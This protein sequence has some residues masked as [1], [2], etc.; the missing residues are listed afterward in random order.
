MA[1]PWM[2]AS[3][4]SPPEPPPHWV[5]RAFADQPALPLTV[6]VG[7][8]GYGKTLGLLALWQAARASADVPGL[9]VGCE[10]ED[11]D[12]ATFFP[13]LVAGLAER[14]P[15]FGEAVLALV[16][17]GKH[18]P[19]ALWQR[20]FEDVAGYNLPGFVL[21]LDDAHYLAAGSDGSL[22]RG[23]LLE[24]LAG[25]L[26]RLPPGCRLLLASRRKLPLALARWQA[27][28][29]ARVIGPEGLRFEAAE[30]RALYVG[31]RGGEPPAG[32]E[33]HV[34]ELEG[35][36]LGVDLA[37]AG[38]SELAAGADPALLAEVIAQELLG[39][40]EGDRQRFMLG[41]ALLAEPTATALAHALADERAAEHLAALEADQLVL[42]LARASHGQKPG[43][44]GPPADARYRFP[45]FLREYL[46]DEARRRLP[47]TER[48]AIHQR[49]GAFYVEQALDE[50]ALPHLQAAKAW[51]AA[52]AAGRRC[53]PIM[54]T[55]GRRA[56]V[57]RLLAGFPPE[58]GQQEPFLL[59]W[60][61]HAHV[62]AFELAAARAI[63]ERARE[64]SAARGD[65]AGEL[66][67]L[68][69]LANVAIWSGDEAEAARLDMAIQPILVDGEP[70]DR[71]DYP[72]ARALLAEAQGDP[73]G[74]RAHNE[75]VLDVP[76]GGSVEVAAART[77]ALINLASWAYHHGQLER[78][79][80]HGDE[81]VALAQEWRFYGHFRLATCIRALPDL[82]RGLPEGL[83]L[84]E[85]LPPRWEDALSFLELGVALVI[86]GWAQQARGEPKAADDALRR[87]MQLFE[88]S[89][90]QEGRKVALERLLSFALQ[91]G[92]PARVPA[93]LAEHLPEGATGSGQHDVPLQL[94][95]GRA[96][97]LL[98]QHAEARA[99]LE[100][101]IAG[102]DAL[103]APLEA[104]RARLFLAATLRATADPGAEAMLA[105]A[106]HAIAA[107]GYAFL[108]EQDARLWNELAAPATHASPLPARKP[109][110]PEPKPGLLTLAC[111]GTFEVRRDGVLLASWPRRKARLVLAVLALQ[112]QRGIDAMALAEL[113]AGD[114]AAVGQAT[115]HQLQMA[116][117][118]LR[119]I[120][121]PDRPG[122][123][124]ASSYLVLRDDRYQLVPER[125][126]LVDLD[127]FDRAL[128]EGQAARD[129]A[130]ALPAFQAAAEL[131]RGPLLAD[132]LFTGLFDAEREHY[133]KRALEVLLWLAAHHGRHMDHA[134]AETA[135]TRALALAP[136]DEDV[137]L[138]AMRHQQARGRAERIRQLYWDCRKALK[139]RLAMAPSAEF[140]QA[141]RAMI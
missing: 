89:G 69:R 26:G 76:I 131:V 141:F 61:G 54:S 132:Q 65:A 48:E 18:D 41:A 27:Q 2:L 108:R 82:V 57:Q 97:H 94:S 4:L 33:R 35:W 129:P 136:T 140:E 45:G 12:A 66:E 10:P 130:I 1:L 68:V 15:G 74:H 110:D 13:Q 75:A 87:A 133:R 21:A 119:A 123:R 14:V 16:A 116:V 71:A 34:E 137:Y 120:L 109:L 112:R 31:R 139:T 98:G 28:G 36:P 114:E 95:L 20:F 42:R 128:A 6:L 3:K 55:F 100:R 135:F 53:F 84:P 39:S 125:L 138:A 90:F 58:L 83:A 49:A 126:A 72:L 96:R 8:P 103:D 79:A 67:A 60:Q 92:Q 81:A 22:P 127:A 86:V 106:E 24:G 56:A 9:W 25:M 118:A 59:L 11:A 29:V 19:R 7:G 102:F 121:E 73:V 17:A 88:R 70:K 105:D 32:W 46:R 51:P 62:R 122:Q 124:G 30:A 93:L 43:A 77:I 40:Q 23:A 5:P 44:E 63:Y 47:A 64:A 115:M 113:V 117:S 50:L 107:H 104:T 134:S 101:A 111:L 37:A 52:L 91:R 38:G 85:R 80:R 99:A 78:A